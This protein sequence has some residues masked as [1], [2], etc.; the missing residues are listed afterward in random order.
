MKV[1]ICTVFD[2]DVP[3]AGLN[4][5]NHMSKALNPFGIECLISVGSGSIDMEG[6][7]WK[8]WEDQNQKYIIFDKKIFTAK[9]H[10][11]A[12]RITATAAK[13]Y[14]KYLSEIIYK[15]SISGIIVYSPQSQLVSP[16]FSICQKN[17]AFVIA[18]CTENF[19]LSYRHILN[20]V[21]YQQFMF[22]VF[23][24][25]KLHGAIISSPRWLLDTKKA[26]I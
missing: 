3:C 25:K 22:R 15:L 11:N 19:S 7:V 23:Q 13:F 26:N 16:L 4:R 8:Y 17:K 6:E 2:I 24:M 10:C 5:L 12:M 21:I 9:R 1:L 14:K 18:D 20:G